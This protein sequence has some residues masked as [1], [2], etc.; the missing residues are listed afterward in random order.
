MSGAYGLDFDRG[1][2][3]HPHEGDP[4]EPGVRGGWIVN[5]ET[6]AIEVPYGRYVPTYREA[7]MAQDMRMWEEEEKCRRLARKQREEASKVERLRKALR[8]E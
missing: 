7:E 3:D 2:W 4:E 5:R 1:D 8:D 6:G